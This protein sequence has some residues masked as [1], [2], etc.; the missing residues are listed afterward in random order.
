MKIGVLEQ[1]V[2]QVAE[3]QRKLKAEDTSSQQS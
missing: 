3:L 2:K 1:L